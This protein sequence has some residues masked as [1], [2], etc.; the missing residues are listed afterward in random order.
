MYRNLTVAAIV[1]YLLGGVYMIA[2]DKKQMSQPN[3]SILTVDMA[4]KAPAN[5]KVV[6]IGK[7]IPV[8]KKFALQDSTGK[9]TLAFPKEKPGMVNSNLGLNVKITGTTK[10]SFWSK[11]GLDELVLKV[12]KI[13]LIQDISTST[14]AGV[15]K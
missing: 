10:K 8:G 1:F 7:L 14:D 9:I 11:I 4:N 5:T 6:L 12:D 15:K 13:E 2:S 3:L